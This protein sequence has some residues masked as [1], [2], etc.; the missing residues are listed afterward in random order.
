MWL[1][2]GIRNLLLL[3]LYMEF[4]DGITDICTKPLEWHILFSPF[5]RADIYTG[6]TYDARRE[7]E[8]W[9]KPGSIFNKLSKRCPWLIVNT[10]VDRE[11][12][13]FIRKFPA[14]LLPDPGGKLEAQKCEPIKAVEEIKL[15]GCIAQKRV[16]ILLNFP[17]TS[18]WIRIKLCG[19]R[20]KG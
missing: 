13:D 11:D 12:N 17:R 20:G 14:M 10:F 15:K 19:E 16:C 8:G 3:Q 7:I 9:N 4:D 6:E 1:M 5:L 18:G 2:D